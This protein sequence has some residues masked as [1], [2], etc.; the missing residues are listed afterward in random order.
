MIERSARNWHALEIDETLREL[1][2]VNE[3]NT[4]LTSDEVARRRVQF[5]ANELGEAKQPS[6]LWR[7]LRQFN[8]VLIV[9]LIIAAI[10]A[11]ALQH[12]VDAGVVFAVV[13]LNAIIGFIQEGRAES[14][15]QAIRKMV[16]LR[17]V[18]LREGKQQNIEASDLVP[19]D[20]VLLSAGD[21]VPADVRL[22]RVRF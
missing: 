8:N 21:Q 19:G 10:V 6:F 5:G 18:V 22:L 15:L 3:A 9:V 11:A 14:A 12:Y 16:A 17:T 2:V 13:I 1:G 4:G 20:I 7:V